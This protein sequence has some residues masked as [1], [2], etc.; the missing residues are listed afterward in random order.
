[1]CIKQENYYFYV[2]KININYIFFLINI[3][4]FR[5]IIN[6]FNFNCNEK[7][8]KNSEIYTHKDNK[9]IVVWD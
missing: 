8:I 3:L 6:N 1:M 7:K 2:I 4:Y 9:E 5:F